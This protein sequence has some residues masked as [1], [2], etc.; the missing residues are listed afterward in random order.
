[1]KNDGALHRHFSVSKSLMTQAFL[2]AIIQFEGGPFSLRHRRFAT[3]GSLTDFYVI[4]SLMISRSL[5]IAY[6]IVF[7]VPPLLPS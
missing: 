6:F 5:S 3:P 2:M 4:G 7:H 1:M